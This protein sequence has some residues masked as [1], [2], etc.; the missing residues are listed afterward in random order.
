M[1][2]NRCREER[3]FRD[4][5]KSETKRHPYMTLLTNPGQMNDIQCI[6]N[7]YRKHEVSFKILDKGEVRNTN[8]TWC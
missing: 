6:D 8:G 1:L 7:D 3:G 2:A 4:I 5:G